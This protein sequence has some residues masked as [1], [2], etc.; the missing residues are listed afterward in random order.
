MEAKLKTIHSNN[1]KLKI[2][3]RL[4]L[5]NISFAVSDNTNSIERCTY[6]I[7][8][9]I[10]MFVDKTSNTDNSTSVNFHWSFSLTH[11]GHP[12][13]KTRSYHAIKASVPIHEIEDEYLINAI[14]DSYLHS[15]KCVL[16]QQRIT[17]F[18]KLIDFPASF[19]V[20]ENHVLQNYL[21]AL[22]NNHCEQ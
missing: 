2:M 15:A 8:P 10:E 14:K 11:M 4:K 7:P 22:R 5:T 3:T 19:E 9:S 18:L 17:E 6:D 16:E 20:L 21:D 12:A 1:L 13:F